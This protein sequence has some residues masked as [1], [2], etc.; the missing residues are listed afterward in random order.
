M[1]DDKKYRPLKGGIQLQVESYSGPS[2]TLGC[3]AETNRPG[4]PRRIVILS[5]AHCLYAGRSF[6][7]GAITQPGDRSCQP[8]ACSKCSRCC[9]DHIGR[10]LRGEFSQ[11]VDAAI[12]TLYANT[13]VLA[14]VEGIGPIRGVHNI[15]EAEAHNRANPLRV[16]KRGCKTLLTEGEVRLLDFVTNMKGFD[17]GFQRLARGL[18]LV[19]PRT[20]VQLPIRRIEA[21]GVIRVDNA[22]FQALTLNENHVIELTGPTRNRGLFKIEE[23]QSQTEIVAEHPHNPN[24]AATLNAENQTA[25]TPIT[26]YLVDP[27]GINGVL[28]PGLAANNSG[29]LPFDMV[30]IRG[31]V[32]NNGIFQVRPLGTLA[33]DQDQVAVYGTL[34]AEPAGSAEVR[35][36]HFIRVREKSFCEA[37]DSGAVV[38]NDNAEVVALLCG[39]VEQRT[40]PDLTGYG[41]ATPINAVT[42]S[43]GINILTAQNPGQELVVAAAEAEPGTPGGP[44][45]SG[46]DASA[47]GVVPIHGEQREL[48]LRAQRDLLETEDGKMYAELFSR[49]VDEVRT[50]IDTNKRVAVVW[51]RNGGPLLAQ[52]A[53]NAV[54]NP[55]VLIPVHVNDLPLALCLNNILDILD[56]YGS[57]QLKVDIVRT[58]PAWTRFAGMSFN[59]VKSGLENRP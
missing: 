8:D 43:L 6:A 44:I 37:G 15:T 54:Q 9:S 35:G 30:E 34:T 46:R 19:Q 27:S 20:L 50:L 36:L 7:P 11:D 41:F 42:T 40:R 12:S 23:V 56:R 26:A 48:L 10:T 33:I 25:F 32:A 18:V 39:T 31:S 13:R 14:E 24:F 1:A 55:D 57:E 38:V 52:V 47:T 45:A 28:A 4:E 21:N 2:G 49:H 16:R 22:Q 53:L 51:Q 59:Q 29:L 58:R 5:V 3:I 17:G